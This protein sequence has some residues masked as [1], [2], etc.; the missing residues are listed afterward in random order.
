M[1]SLWCNLFRE[2]I[3]Y[4]T[5]HLAFH[6]RRRKEKRN[7]FN[8]INRPHGVILELM[9]LL[10]SFFCLYF[11]IITLHKMETILNDI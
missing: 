10:M 9:R 8:T 7:S 3:N 4:L 2:Q 11:L 1:F 6:L 5:R